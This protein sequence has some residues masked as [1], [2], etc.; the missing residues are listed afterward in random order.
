MQQT[1]FV[2][3]TKTESFPAGGMFSSGPAVTIDEEFDTLFFLGRVGGSSAMVNCSGGG[4]GGNNGGGGSNSSGGGG[5]TSGL[6]SNA[7]KNE[8]EKQLEFLEDE[9]NAV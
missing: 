6:T 1:K 4:G 7:G 9:E 3:P 5:G 2:D 8:A